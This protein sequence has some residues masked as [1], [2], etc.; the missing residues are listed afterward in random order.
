MRAL[1]WWIICLQNLSTRVSLTTHLTLVL[2]PRAELGAA[3]RYRGQ[4]SRYSRQRSTAIAAGIAPAKETGLC[5]RHELPVC[6][7]G[8]PCCVNAY[9]KPDVAAAVR[10][11]ARVS[12]D[13]TR[14][15]DT[16]FLYID[17]PCKVIHPERP[18]PE[19]YRCKLWLEERSARSLVVACETNASHLSCV[20]YRK[21][22]AAEHATG[23]GV[24]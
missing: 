10:L 4:I 12:L 19:W 8:P 18:Q 2:V 3:G 5:V 20:D 6:M 11:R 17:G 22:V 14:T 13:R 7:Y 1:G 24:D 23:L 21:L 15:V 16:T 9:T